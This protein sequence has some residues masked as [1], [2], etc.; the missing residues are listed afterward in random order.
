[1]PG[2][3]NRMTNQILAAALLM[4]SICRGAQLT[5]AANVAFGQYVASLEA[6]LALQHADAAT[7]LAMLNVDSSRRIVLERQLMAG[8][9]RVEP[10]N[11]A[12]RDVPGALLHHWRGSAFVANATPEEMLALLRDHSH[13]YPHYAPRVIASRALKD[14]GDT[15]ILAVR[16]KEQTV[17][18]IVLDAEYTFE[19]R[20]A[21]ADRGYSLSRSTH[22]WQ[23]DDPGTP[24]ERRRPAGDDEGFLWRLNSYWSFERTHGGL[25][26]ECEAVS[27]T[28]DVP[29]G[30]GWLVMPFVQN[31]PSEE[32][33]FT[34]AK[35]REALT[36]MTAG[37]EQR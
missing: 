22:I 30:L 3:G 19:S 20:L 4:S 6:R 2:E 37:K 21:G 5:Q 18:T 26:I 23:V 13:V 14:E 33:Q 7:H 35:S 28:R 1:M 17:R 34:L 15:A 16:L 29:F 11:G 36:A 25:L 24:Q 10:V 9:I 27:L 32:L 31:L 12:V 8:E